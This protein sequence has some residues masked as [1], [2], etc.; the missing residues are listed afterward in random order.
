MSS[1]TK[2]DNT[3]VNI[4]NKGERTK[5]QINISANEQNKQTAK[6]RGYQF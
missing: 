5:K 2:S 4:N 6:K 3:F 1:D